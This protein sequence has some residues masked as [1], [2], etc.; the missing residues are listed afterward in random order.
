VLE[1]WATVLSRPEPARIIVGFGKRD[2]SHDINLPVPF[3]WSRDG[4]IVGFDGGASVAML[5]DQHAFV[6]VDAR[7]EID[8]GDVVGLAVSHPCTAL[9]KWKMLPLVD[10]DYVV[11]GAIAT[12]F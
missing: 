11:T 6:S 1:L 8:V 9:D 4:E 2:V 10:D 5:N 7:C 3:G 12:Y